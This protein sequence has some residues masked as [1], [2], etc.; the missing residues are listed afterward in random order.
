MGGTMRL[1]N[2]PCRLERRS[3]AR[4]IYAKDT[5]QERHRH[6]YEVNPKYIKNLS[7]K[8]LLFSGKSPNGKLMEIVEVPD[9]PFYIGTQFHPEFTSG[10]LAPNPIFYNFIKSSLENL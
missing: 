8:G 9:H 3:L 2:W 1:G 10:P 7:T 6:R 4:K 5:V